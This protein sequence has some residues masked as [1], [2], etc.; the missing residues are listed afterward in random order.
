MVLDGVEERKG[1][2][3]D[4]WEKRKAAGKI[5][6]PTSTTGG[7]GGGGGGGGEYRNLDET[8]EMAINLNVDPRKPGQAIRIQAGVVRAHQADEALLQQ[9]VLL[10]PAPP[11]RDPAA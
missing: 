4:R 5:I 3:A 7:G 10:C 1:K 2:R 11:R 6:P 9:W 8:I